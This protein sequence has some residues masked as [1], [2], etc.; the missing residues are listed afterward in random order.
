MHLMY[1]GLVGHSS[2]TSL[3][4]SCMVNPA[5]LEDRVHLSVCTVQ[6]G[7]QIA[8]E[9]LLVVALQSKERTRRN[10][11]RPTTSGHVRSNNIWSGCGLIGTINLKARITESLGRN[12]TRAKCQIQ[13][14]ENSRE[15]QSEDQILTR[16]V[17]GS[18]GLER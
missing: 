2:T 3:I 6:A 7:A 10:K 13:H 18:K 16:E 15:M 4:P 14:Q 8:R 17:Q 9:V 1:L 12:C 5:T 11:S